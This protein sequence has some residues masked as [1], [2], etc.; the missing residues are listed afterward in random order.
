MVLTEEAVSLQELILENSPFSLLFKMSKYRLPRASA[1]ITTGFSNWFLSLPA[2]KVLTVFLHIQNAIPRIRIPRHK[3]SSR[4]T[5]MTSQTR[6]P[7]GRLAGTSSQEVTPESELRGAV[8]NGDHLGV[9]KKKRKRKRISRK[10]MKTEA[11]PASR[12]PVSWPSPASRGRHPE[13]LNWP[14]PRPLASTPE[15]PALLSGVL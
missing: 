3:A 10:R 13:S 5:N 12:G 9:K 8:P 4:R 11:M 15:E 6:N 7:S 1:Y 14:R 2:G